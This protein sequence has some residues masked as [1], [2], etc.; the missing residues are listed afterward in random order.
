MNLRTKLLCGLAAVL[1]AGLA[2]QAQVPGVNST[3]NSVFTLAYDNST[4]KQTYSASVT[5][6][7]AAA[8]TDVCTINGSATR[9]VRVRRLLFNMIAT[10]IQ[11]DPFAVIKRSTANLA[12]TATDPTIVPHDSSNS[13]ATAFVTVYTANAGTLG[14]SVGLVADPYV[15]NGNLT[16]GG[17]VTGITVFEFAKEQPIVL[18]GVA[19]TLS[20]NFNALTYPSA[21]ASCTWEWTEE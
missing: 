7:P 20:L 17:P 18:R 9:N 4:M 12:G 13:A 5:F 14:T 16:T 21:Q 3:L 1:V 10:T 6:V 15:T 2:A 11:S 19:Q 8:A